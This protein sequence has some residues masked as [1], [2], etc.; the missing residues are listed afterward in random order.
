MVHLF[1]RFAAYTSF[2]E[3][4]SELD[5]GGVAGGD[6]RPGAGPG[7]VW[8]LATMAYGL[9]RP[10]REGG[11]PSHARTLDCGEG[12][13]RTSSAQVSNTTTALNAK[14]RASRASRHGRHLLPPMPF[15]HSG[16]GKGVVGFTDSQPHLEDGTTYYP[17]RPTRLDKG[18]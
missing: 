10:K 15:L 8:R 6:I 9:V 17:R 14:R 18:L 1:R 7:T 5:G 4:E 13:E 11:I 2:L 12:G 16:R 3:L